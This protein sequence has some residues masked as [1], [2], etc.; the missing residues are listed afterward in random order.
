MT[1]R[2]KV[3]AR[4]LPDGQPFSCTG[5]EA[6]TL[7]LLLQKGAAGVE[8]YDFRGGPPFRL[9]AYCHS[10]IKH[11]GLH[12]ETQRV[13]HDGGWHGRFVLH[14]LVKIIAV[15]NPNKP[16]AEQVAA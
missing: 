12:I 13:K 10:L 16:L 15:V 11:K 5:Q 7:L 14:T 6:K 2:L 8:A 9:P 4:I 1:K 3:A